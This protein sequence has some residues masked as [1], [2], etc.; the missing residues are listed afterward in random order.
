MASS[1]HHITEIS[2]DYTFKLLTETFFEILKFCL[3]V[4]FTAERPSALFV[5]LENEEKAEHK[6]NE[7]EISSC[8]LNTCTYVCV[9]DF[10]DKNPYKYAVFF[11]PTYIF[12]VVASKFHSAIND[13]IVCIFTYSR[14]K[15]TFLY[16]I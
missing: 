13:D 7:N 9:R 15:H 4:C 12:F 6:N 10:A 2:R 5:N 1:H 14:I 16:A 11:S 3:K 8:T